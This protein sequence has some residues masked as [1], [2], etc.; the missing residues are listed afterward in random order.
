MQ[1]G[2][3]IKKAARTIQ[4]VLSNVPHETIEKAANSHSIKKTFDINIVKVPFFTNDENVKKFIEEFD[5][6]KPDR[7]V[8]FIVESY[9]AQFEG[10][11]ESVGNLEVA[12]FINSASKIKTGKKKIDFGFDNPDRLEE[13]LEKAQDDITSG[14]T[15]LIDKFKNIY[16]KK[17]YDVDNRSSWN[18]FIKSKASLKD[19][20]LNNHLAKATITSLID[21]YNMQIAI[22]TRMNFNINSIHRDFTEFSDWMD[23]NKIGRLMHSYDDEPENEFWLT[24]PK[25]IKGIESKENIILNYIE[26]AEDE[27]FEE[28]IDF[29]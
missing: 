1:N 21:A 13:S 14:T 7:F 29:S 16:T 23:G 19:I 18:F 5:L 17:I 26:D 27:F 6:T 3:L 12:D 9:F 11:M 20:D 24:A 22:G 28:D 25:E 2:K 8:Q 4:T 15:E 10:I